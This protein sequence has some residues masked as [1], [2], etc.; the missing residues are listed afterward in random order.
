MN[1]KTLTIVIPVKDRPDRLDVALQSLAN[2]DD[3]EFSVIVIDHNSTE[4]ISKI[5]EKYQ[6]MLSLKYF[7]TNEGFGPSAP[8]NIGIKY[9]KSAWIGFLDS[10]DRYNSD[11]IRI[12]KK[13]MKDDVDLIYHK[14]KIYDEVVNDRIGLRMPRSLGQD[15]TKGDVVRNLIKNGNQIPTSSVIV[16]HT[17]IINHPF[18][19][20]EKNYSIIEDYTAWVNLAIFGARFKFIPKRLGE[21]WIW[22][23]NISKFNQNQHMR[24]KRTYSY[25]LDLLPEKYKELAGKCFNYELGKQS[26][27]LNN[28]K[29]QY[30]NDISPRKSPIIWFKSRIYLLR[31]Y[32]VSI[33]KRDRFE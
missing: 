28:K 24:Y 18:F 19:V 26:C 1:L 22:N 32:L 5:I 27:R 7:K 15:I 10:D 2:Q 31:Y 12:V 20:S 6:N 11:K 17:W 9:S 8:R 30:F 21:Y 29:N 13:Y 3:K 16:R 14:L 25:I 23:G 4:N 33:A